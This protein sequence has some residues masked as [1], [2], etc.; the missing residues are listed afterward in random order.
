M[1][2]NKDIIKQMRKWE[3]SLAHFY[4]P[5]A[6]SMDRG[7]NKSNILNSSK[8]REKAIGSF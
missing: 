2:I 3:I 4:I 6:A 7:E 5:H 8:F 1:E